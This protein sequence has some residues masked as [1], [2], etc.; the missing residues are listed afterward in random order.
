MANHHFT[1]KCIQL[2]QFK[3]LLVKCSS[4]R[5]QTSFTSKYIKLHQEQDLSKQVLFAT[6]REQTASSTGTV[7]EGHGL[8]PAPH[9]PWD[10]HRLR[11]CRGEGKSPE[12]SRSPQHAFLCLFS[13]LTLKKKK[14]A[15]TLTSSPTSPTAA[16][17]RHTTEPALKVATRYDYTD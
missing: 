4:Q 15:T 3:Q 1:S 5:R 6:F 16:L 12:D 9:Q 13:S 14:A 10:R 7:P 17:T 11:S 2:L 8:V